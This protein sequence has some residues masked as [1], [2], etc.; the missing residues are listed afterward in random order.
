MRTAITISRDAKGVTSLISGPEVEC[1]KQRSAFNALR[2]SGL[3]AGA[4]AVEF[5]QP[6]SRPKILHR[7]KIAPESA[8]THAPETP[9]KKKTLTTDAA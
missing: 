7:A 2:Y 5:W 1:N 8:P 9:K 4:V 6:G 3:P